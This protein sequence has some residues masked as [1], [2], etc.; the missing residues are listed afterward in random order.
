VREDPRQRANPGL[1]RLMNNLPDDEVVVLAPAEWLWQR[2][3]SV[4]DVLVVTPDGPFPAGSIVHAFAAKVP[5]VGTPVDAVREHVT[6]RH[7]GLI[8]A[9]M[10]PR[11]IASALEDFFAAPELRSRLTEQALSD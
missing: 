10:R 11:S 8:A 3:M 2:L 7:N 4:A 6:D 9:T 5:V 1:E